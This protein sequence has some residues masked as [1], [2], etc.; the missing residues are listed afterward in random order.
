M[1]LHH[2][3]ASTFKCKCIFPTS[4]VDDNS[5]TIPEQYC[6]LVKIVP[7]M[8]PDSDAGKQIYKSGVELSKM[9]RFQ[10][11]ERNDFKVPM[12]SFLEG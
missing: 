8:K 2:T 11:K 6:F 10:K 9:K 4:C 3:P 5:P 12:V 7:G 1:N